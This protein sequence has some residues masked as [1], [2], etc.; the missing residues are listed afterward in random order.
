MG[1]FLFMTSFSSNKPIIFVLV[2]TFLLSSLTL[3][4][5]LKNGVAIIYNPLTANFVG[6]S[7]YTSKLQ[8]AIYALEDNQIVADLITTTD[9]R[10]GALDYYQLAI[11]LGDSCLSLSE[12]TVYRDYVTSGGHLLATYDTSLRDDTGKLNEDF[13]LG[14]L[15]EITLLKDELAKPINIEFTDQSLFPSDSSE[16][17]ANKFLPVKS[18]LS[19][20]A[21]A[22]YVSQGNKIEGIAPIVLNQAGM[23][24]A[25][26]LF[27]EECDEKLNQALVM[28]CEFFLGEDYSG[29]AI[30]MSV[31]DLKPMIDEVRSSYKFTER[32]FRKAKRSFEEI[33]PEAE[34][35]YAEAEKYYEAITFALDKNLGHK[36][37]SYLSTLK[38][39]TS[40]M[41][42]ATLPTRK[43]EAR[44]VWI[45]Y[46]SIE[47]SKTEADLKAI[48]KKLSDAGINMIFPET[49][50]MGAT[51]Y[52]TKVGKQH[53]IYQELNFDPLAVLVSECHKVG[54]E[55]HP[56]VWVF[57]GG[58]WNKL[59]PILTDH[60]EWIELDEAGRTF[61]N[62]VW[63]TAW[64]NASHP[65]ARKYLLN[66]YQELVSNYDVDGLH[67]DYIRYNED[68]I[69]HFGFSDY[70]KQDFKTTSGLD[71]DKIR[72][73]SREW[74]KFNEW[75][76]NNVTTFVE[77]VKNMLIS[78]KPGALL[79]AAVVPDPEY[80][81][82]HVMQ[83]W[84]H[85]V[86]NSYLDF[87]MTMDYQN[88]TP[89]F[90]AKAQKG[91]DMVEDKAWVY[92]GL[93]L[94]VNDRINNQGQIKATRQ[95][96]ATGVALFSNIS[97]TKDKYADS[98]N[99]LFREKAVIPMRE[100]FKAASLLLGETA[101]KL[102]KAGL[103]KEALSA[104]ELS[105]TVSLWVTTSANAVKLGES[106]KPL[107]ETLETLRKERELTA[108]EY[109]A[110]SSPLIVVERI[111]AI[112]LY[113]N[114]SKEYIPVKPRT[115]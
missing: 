19:G 60:P 82:A 111:S 100:P 114:S 115:N 55:V 98:K 43:A 112:L 64:V 30:P 23:Y 29:S 66:L 76:E 71:L 65:E 34:N 53:A 37:V 87:V 113:Q 36:A 67:I 88:N 73:G 39:L 5:D 21:K 13:S 11:F 70:S 108:P 28:A 96:G 46:Q 26:D 24:F 68:D 14:D 86:D 3:A 15:F 38:E 41:L 18:L 107:L 102:Q 48:V 79:S 103:E 62:W 12:Q 44:A 27:S 85:W 17:T 22:T 6:E 7:E 47:A 89:A 16:V 51:I 8:K 77:E 110:L 1:G 9:V 4:I 20:S 81:R 84:K 52:P 106:I 57:C 75:R 97:F 49:Y 45:D 33:S 25:E 35:A 80:S 109:E 92:P 101:S 104:S 90:K 61:S 105:K 31:D 99:G 93:G 94:Y 74:I 72:I 50:Y 59:G 56:W 78:T 10:N 58:Y 91:L 32:E 54:I 42:Q 63:G 40:V 69:G 2:L 83:N 95:V